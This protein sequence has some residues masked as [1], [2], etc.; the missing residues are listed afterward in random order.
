[1]YNNEVYPDSEQ[2]GFWLI[3]DKG[4]KQPA[5]ETHR[6]YLEWARRFVTTETARTGQTPDA[7]V[8]RK[9]AL[10]YFKNF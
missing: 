4:V 5:Y 9:A 10:E 2:R 7:A 3:D 6:R 1:M 8:F